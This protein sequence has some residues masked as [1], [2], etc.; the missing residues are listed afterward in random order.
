ME[1]PILI[2][3]PSKIGCSTL[4]PKISPLIDDDKDVPIAHP[5]PIAVLPV[6]V[7]VPVRVPVGVIPIGIG[8]NRRAIVR[9]DDS[10]VCPPGMICPIGAADGRATA[11]VNGSSITSLDCCAIAVVSYLSVCPLVGIGVEG[12]RRKGE[13]N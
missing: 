5:P 7:A 2:V 8:V 6:P 3:K 4:R 11:S 1:R 12:G 13:K 10:A 9:M